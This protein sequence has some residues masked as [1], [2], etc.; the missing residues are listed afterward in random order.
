MDRIEWLTHHYKTLSAF[1]RLG[2]WQ[3][4]LRHHR[5]RIAMYWLQWNMCNS[6]KWLSQMW[7]RY[8]YRL[9]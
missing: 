6:R 5:A 8:R 1:W 4:F 2:K 7:A 3:I 9:S